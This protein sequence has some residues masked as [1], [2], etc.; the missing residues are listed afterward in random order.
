MSAR[1]E[2]ESEL[3]TFS[4]ELI[5]KP[6]SIPPNKHAL[7]IGRPVIYVYEQCYRQG[8]LESSIVKKLEAA[9]RKNMDEWEAVH[10]TS[11]RNLVAWQMSRDAL[12]DLVTLR[13]P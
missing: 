1:D 10:P 12:S 11:F 8:S 13:K 7:Y 3:E 6:F 2:F 4:A 5:S 9:L